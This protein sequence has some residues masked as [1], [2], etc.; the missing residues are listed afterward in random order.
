MK[1]PVSILILS[2]LFLKVRDQEMWTEVVKQ[3]TTSDGEFVQVW[4]SWQDTAHT[5]VQEIWG[6]DNQLYGFVVYQANTVS[7]VGLKSIDENTIQFSWRPP[8]PV[9]GR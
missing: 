9:G 7:L 5:G 2:L 1:K 3:H 4:G 8:Q 6:P